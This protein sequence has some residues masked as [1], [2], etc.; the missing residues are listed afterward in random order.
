ML[1]NGGGY[2]RLCTYEQDQLSFLML[3]DWGDAGRSKGKIVAQNSAY[4]S[5]GREAGPKALTKLGQK[6]RG[7]FWRLPADLGQWHTLQVNLQQLYDQAAGANAFATL[8]PNKLLVTVGVWCL[9]DKGSH[10]GALFDD[11]ALDFNR[12]Q[13]SQI[14]GQAIQVDQTVFQPGFAGSSTVTKATEIVD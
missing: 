1:T 9:R 3:F 10:S 13:P 4:V 5:T 11:L 14:N 2:I 12:N 6:K 8:K 7:L